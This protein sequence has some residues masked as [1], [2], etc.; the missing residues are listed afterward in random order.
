[1]PYDFGKKK[2]DDE[3]KEEGGYA[4]E[5]GKSSKADIHAQIGKK[6]EEMLR[7]CEKLKGG[8]DDAD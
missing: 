8:D 3:E 7:L 5:R 4:R 6:F 1:M 2:D